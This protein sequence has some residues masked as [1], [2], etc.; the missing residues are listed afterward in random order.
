MKDELLSDEKIN[1]A[2]AEYVVS[3]IAVLDLPDASSQFTGVCTAFGSHKFIITAT[4]CLDD[5]DPARLVVAT[6]REECVGR[7]L[8][9]VRVVACNTSQ[10][11]VAVI[12]V[13]PPVADS[14]PVNWLEHNRL[15]SQPIAEGQIVSV[16][17]FPIDLREPHHPPPYTH[18]YPKACILMSR[19]ASWSQKI[20]PSDRPITPDVDIFV[21]YTPDLFIDTR[22]R[23]VWI[24]NFPGGMSGSP[25]FWVPTLYK[26]LNS[27]L[28]N[29]RLSGI[30][31]SHLGDRRPVRAHRIEYVDKLMRSAIG[32]SP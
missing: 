21:E 13:P 18:V 27:H 31:S 12:L 10:I 23:R 28:A 22:G 3:F 24:P 17:G 29:I 19:V 30:Q 2:V 8:R 11:D 15:T 25:V 7:P 14:L 4:H 16:A 9:P 20:A 6:A 26:H 1:Q 32:A 5:L